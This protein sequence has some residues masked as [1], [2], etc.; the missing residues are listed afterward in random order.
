MQ[1]RDHFDVLLKD[2]VNLCQLK[3]DLLEATASTPSIGRSK[4]TTKS[5]R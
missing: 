3:L 5:G 2:T 1:L 4:P